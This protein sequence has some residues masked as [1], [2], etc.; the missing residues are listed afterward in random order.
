MGYNA[1]WIELCECCNLVISWLW[2]QSLIVL[3]SLARVYVGLRWSKYSTHSTICAS[4]VLCS[5]RVCTVWGINRVVLRISICSFCVTLLDFTSPIERSHFRYY[6][7]DVWRVLAHFCSEYSRARPSTSGCVAV[8][9]THHVYSANQLRVLNRD[10]C[11][12]C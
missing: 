3:P 2:T 5:G 1:V 4:D 9:M 10:C 12:N 11:S 8:F 7:A 6:C